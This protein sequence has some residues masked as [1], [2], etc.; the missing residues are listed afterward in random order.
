MLTHD[1]YFIKQ[2]NAVSEYDTVT[3]TL[4]RYWENEDY[5]DF[6]NYSDSINISGWSDGPYLDYHPQIEAAQIY[7]FVNNYISEYL[8]ADN[9]FDK[10]KAL[11]D[12]CGLLDEFY[13]LDN[14]H[15]IYGKLAVGDTS[16]EKV[17]QIY[18]N[19][20][21]ILKTY[22]YVSDEQVQ[23]IRTADST[24]IQLIIEESVKNKY[25]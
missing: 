11:T 3:A 10:N 21:A 9:I 19:M 8:A 23:A 1:W 22:F 15:Y 4:D 24:Q 14:L 17:E 2:K 16:D 18:K 20:D 6:F 5:Y 7:I 12:I 25:E 13:D